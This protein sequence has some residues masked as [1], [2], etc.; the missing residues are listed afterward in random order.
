MV[1]QSSQMKCLGKKERTRFLGEYFVETRW[2][3]YQS[4]PKHSASSRASYYSDIRRWEKFLLS[5]FL[6][7]FHKSANWGISVAL[8]PSRG[9]SV[10]LG[11]HKSIFSRIQVKRNNFHQLNLFISIFVNSERDLISSQ[12]S[13]FHSDFWALFFSMFWKLSSHQ[14]LNSNRILLALWNF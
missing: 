5:N 6:L 8:G 10:A 11:H 2:A 13:M 9:I 14:K 4:S 1:V 3:K 12:Y 7:T